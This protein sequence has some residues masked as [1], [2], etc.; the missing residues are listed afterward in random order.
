MYIHSGRLKLFSLHSS[1]S[2]YP[3]LPHI[4]RFRKNP[5]GV[6]FLASLSEAHVYAMFAKNPSGLL[7]LSLV[8]DLVPAFARPSPAGVCTSASAAGVWSDALPA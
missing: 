3:C 1:N 8:E 7:L 5:T 2:R 6:G 4:Y